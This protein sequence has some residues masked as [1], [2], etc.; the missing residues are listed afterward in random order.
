M[1]NIELS[2]GSFIKCKSLIFS[3]FEAL[4]LNVLEGA[5]EKFRNQFGVDVYRLNNKQVIASEGGYYMLFDNVDDVEKLLIDNQSS[6]GTEVLSN[7]NSF[8][9]DF[10]N[11][12]NALIK[13]LSNALSVKYIYLDEQ[14]LKDLD[15]K[16][17]KLSSTSEL[18]KRYLINF[19]AVIGEVLREKYNTEWIMILSDDG[20]TWNPYLKSTKGNPIN[21][22]IYLYED[23]YVNNINSGDLLFEIYQTVVDI[24]TNRSN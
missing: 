11:H 15:Y 24:N 7:K 5:I 6:D 17:N 13:E 9:K 12:T 19:I 16:I 3:E 21:F 22:F 18:K 14:L 10:P 2:N 8:G 1:N 20:K 4:R 23:I